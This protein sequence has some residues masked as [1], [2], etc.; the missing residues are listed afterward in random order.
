MTSTTINI[1]NNQSTGM[2]D[3]STLVTA[4]TK[5]AVTIATSTDIT[6]FS[7]SINVI[8]ATSNVLVLA[9]I[10]LSSG[11]SASGFQVK[12]DGVAIYTPN[13]PG[14]RYA[15]LTGGDKYSGIITPVTLFFFD[16]GVS[17]GV[18]TYDFILNTQNSTLSVNIGNQTPA[19]NPK[20]LVNIFLLEL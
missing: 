11:P 18:H 3:I 15:G 19:L 16:S 20:T 10:P 5:T 6:L 13:S 9:V 7:K 4:D 2:K 14:S 8:G 1:S 12:R 17:S